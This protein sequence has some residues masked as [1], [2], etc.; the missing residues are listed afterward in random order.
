MYLPIPSQRTCAQAWLSAALAI[1][2]AGREAYNVIVDI[3]E[4]LSITAT[5]LRIISH[6]DAFLKNHDSSRKHVYPLIS[7]A[8][9][10]FPYDLYRR[11]GSPT[12][13]DIYLNKVYPRIKKPNE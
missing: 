8:N 7:I 6:V 1:N 10:I 4:P 13:Y 5:D 12:F 9:T 2:Q 3:E 11:F